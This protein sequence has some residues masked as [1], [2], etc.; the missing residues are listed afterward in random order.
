MKVKNAIEAK[1]QQAF[2]LHYLEV[3]N[4]SYMHSVPP[5]SETHFKLVIVSPLFADMRSVA[6]HQTVYKL[7]AY[8]LQNGVHALALHTYSVE[9]WQKRQQQAPESPACMGGSKHD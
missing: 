6:R 3:L 9:E 5:N 8:E 1:L 4:E 7:L 2:D